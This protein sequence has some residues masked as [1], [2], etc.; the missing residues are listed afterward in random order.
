MQWLMGLLGGIFLFFNQTK[1]CSFLAGRQAHPSKHA[2]KFS[3]DKRTHSFSQSH[4]GK[5]LCCKPDQLPSRPGEGRVCGGV[6]LIMSHRM[7][8]TLC[9]LVH[10][11]PQ[12]KAHNF[13]YVAST[14]RIYFP[15]HKSALWQGCLS[16]TGIGKEQEVGRT[17]EA[18]FC[19]ALV[20]WPVEPSPIIV[21]MFCQ[22]KQGGSF[23][24][25]WPCD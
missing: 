25:A 4:R 10:P 9:L 20:S 1:P 23:L 12:P 16:R 14:Y 24:D 7:D 8:S 17:H 3:F 11:H 6:K 5:R 13:H 19:W 21:P 18:F 22:I 15:A 2:E